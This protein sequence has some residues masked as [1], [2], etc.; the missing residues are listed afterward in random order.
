MVVLELLSRGLL[1]EDETVL[2]NMP[3]WDGCLPTPQQLV[4]MAGG[5][6]DGKPAMDSIPLCELQTFGV[7]EE[8]LPVALGITNGVAHTVES[9][10]RR[11]R[12]YGERAK[13]LLLDLPAGGFA[14]FTDGGSNKNRTQTGWGVSDPTFTFEDIV[15][16]RRP[17][18]K[19]PSPARRKR[20]D[21]RRSIL[22][23]AARYPFGGDGLK[24][25]M[26]SNT[27]FLGENEYGPI[28]VSS[29]ETPLSC[30]EPTISLLEAVVTKDPRWHWLE[31]AWDASVGLDSPFEASL[32]PQRCFD[33]HQYTATTVVLKFI[34]NG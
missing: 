2:K 23:T 30:S 31:A 6:I 19:Q 26:H 5:S 9:K 13:Q 1:R 12:A 27:L 22:R 21:V 14:L 10:S 11:D 17:N 20:H 29:A 18:R 3:L 25:G 34:A 33:N 28:R 8:P 16:H 24:H 4:T 32:L 15:L 7:S